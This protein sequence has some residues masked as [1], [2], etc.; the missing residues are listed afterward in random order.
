VIG[1][2]IILGASWLL[3]FLLEKKNLS[4]LGF[5]P[6]SE[7]SI[8]FLLGFGFISIIQSIL[9][10]TETYVLSTVWELKT[11]ISL[12]HIFGSLWYHLK[13]ALT[14]DLLFRGAALCI[15]ASRF[16]NKAAIL[17]SAILFGVYHWFS[18]GMFGAGLVPMVYVFVITGVSGAVWAY[19]YFKTN[20]IFLALG[21]HVGWNFISTLFLDNQPYGELLFQQISLVPISNDWLNFIFQFTKGLAPSII[22]Y[23]FVRYLYNEN[24][25]KE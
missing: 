1:I 23:F 14:E 2:L 7:R 3:L 11:N 25:N 20:S 8:Q 10:L 12:S 18:Y 4:V 16:N 19:S 22:T 15:L 9:I 24:R 21:L 13:S 17:S 5:T 6:V